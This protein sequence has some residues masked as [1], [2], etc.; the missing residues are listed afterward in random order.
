M[1]NNDMS[2]F[3]Q[4]RF[5]ENDQTTETSCSLGKVKTRDM[6]IRIAE[7]CYVRYKSGSPCIDDLTQVVRFNV[8]HAFAVNAQVLGFNNDWL[9]YEATSPF[10][11]SGNGVLPLTSAGRPRAMDPTSLQF[12]VEHHPWIDFFPCPR[13]RDN[14]LNAVAPGKE[15]IDEDELCHDIVHGGA[16][17]GVDG[18]ALIAW[19]NPWEP[20]GWEFTES[21]V[22]KWGLLLNGCAELMEATNR[23]RKK[24]GLRGLQL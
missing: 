22:R 14:L 17:A 10:N 20:G 21:F 24:R 4:V 7:Q 6:M 19:G 18:A 16:N 12:C 8:F 1:D 9:T 2:I 3:N 23:W 5:P 11:I 13:L 15:L